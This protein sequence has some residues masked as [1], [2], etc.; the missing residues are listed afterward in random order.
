MNKAEVR[1]LLKEQ[2]TQGKYQG[3]DVSHL[4]LRLI[5]IDKVSKL[6]KVARINTP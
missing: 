1:H 4:Q 3:K 5:E 6:K 2:I